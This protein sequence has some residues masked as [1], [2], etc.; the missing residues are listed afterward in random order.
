MKTRRP[1]ALKKVLKVNIG[2][3]LLILV[4]SARV[5][6]YCGG[7][8]GSFSACGNLQKAPPFQFFDPVKVY[9]SEKM[10]S[11]LPSP[12]SEL[13]LGMT[14]GIDDLSKNPRFKDQ[15]KR[16]GT[17]HVVVVSGFNMSLVAGY[18][19]KVFGSPYKKRNLFLTIV[20]T[21]LYAAFTG[22][23]PPVVRAW[24]MTTFMLIGKYSGRLLNSLRLLFVSYIVIVIINPLNFFSMSTYLSF[25]A[26]L[27]LIIF[28]EPIQ[29]ILFKIAT[30]KALFL[31]DF[32]SS[33]AAQIT[34]WPLLSGVFGQVS[35]ISLIVNALVLWT[36]PITTV[37]GMA[38]LVFPGKLVALACLPFCDIF[39][40]VV[41]FFSSFPLASINW[42]MPPFLL[43]FYYSAIAVF[44]IFATKR[45]GKSS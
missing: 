37:V 30:K 45:S 7:T 40:R 29:K 44:T 1:L 25:L 38:A 24:V 33:L 21:F 16:T 10:R 5:F 28:S 19:S 27:G 20:A 22:F 4:S 43:V 39:I 35:L 18:A 6:F 42:K 14:I 23:E 9:L 31:E 34:V 41:E 13:V 32:S 2:L 12:H 11:A 15:L 26:T 36:V 8:L 3:G 17:I